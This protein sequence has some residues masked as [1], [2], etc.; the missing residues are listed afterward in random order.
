MRLVY[1]SEMLD[2]LPERFTDIQMSDRKYGGQFNMAHA[3]KRSPDELGRGMYSK[4]TPSEDPH[5]VDKT[6]I[7]PLGPAHR[8]KADG[9]AFFVNILVENDLMDNIH[10]PKVYKSAKTTD[11]TNTHRHGFTI[12]KLEP[13]DNLSDEEFNSLIETHMLRPCASTTVLADQLND[14]CNN[15]YGRKNYIRME[16]LRDA[17]EILDEIDDVSDFRMD[18]HDGNIMVRRTPHGPQL[19]FSDPFG[20]V[21]AQYIKN[22]S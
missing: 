5:M 20:S 21:K 8:S 13:I 12:E 11:S 19:V 1:L 15:A 14:A 4:V 22:Y 16:S 6:S 3:A 18:L 7:R 10:F 17:C 2:L 9:F